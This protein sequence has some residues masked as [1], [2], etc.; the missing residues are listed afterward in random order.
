[1]SVY[2]FC[3]SLKLL[4]NVAQWY[5]VFYLPYPYTSRRFQK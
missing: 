4:S 5:S 1:L 2:I 3:I